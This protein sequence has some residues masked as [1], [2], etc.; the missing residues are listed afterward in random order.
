MF[1]ASWGLFWTQSWEDIQIHNQVQYFLKTNN[2]LELFLSEKFN[3]QETF[4]NIISFCITHN[5]ILVMAVKR[6]KRHFKDHNAT[7]LGKKT[8]FYIY[9]WYLRV[10]KI[11][12][13]Y[14][15][16]F[17]C[18]YKHGKLFAW[19]VKYTAHMWNTE[20]VRNGGQQVHLLLELRESSLLT[21]S[22]NSLKIWCD[23]VYS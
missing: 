23:L 14:V 10:I 5:K 2:D 13:D 16:V 6:R 12:P 21:L 4:K 19:N 7:I 1:R 20:G 9:I 17:P 15:G 8:H 3:I 11:Q 18:V 22:I